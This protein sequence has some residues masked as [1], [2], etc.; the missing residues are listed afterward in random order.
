[1]LG[2][3]FPKEYRVLLAE[4]MIVTE[5]AAMITIAQAMVMVSE[6]QPIDYEKELNGR[7]DRVLSVLELTKEDLSTD[8]PRR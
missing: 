7:I 3:K 5:T 2:I 4:H 6:E 8:V 1:M